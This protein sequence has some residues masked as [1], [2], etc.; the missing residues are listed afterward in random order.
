LQ[1]DIK[2]KAFFPAVVG[3]AACLGLHGEGKVVRV[4]PVEADARA[5]FAMAGRLFVMR[6]QEHY[7]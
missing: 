1:A 7:R 6:R 4:E 5:G 3:V 2:L